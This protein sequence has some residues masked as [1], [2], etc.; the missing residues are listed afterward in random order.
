M[1]IK[2]IEEKFGVKVIVKKTRCCFCIEPEKIEEVARFFIF[3]GARLAAITGIDGSREV[4]LL[5][6]FTIKNMVISVKT[7]LK[8]PS[9]KIKSITS[10]IHNASWHEREIHDLFNVN[11]LN[12]PDLKPLIIFEE[13]KTSS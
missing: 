3:S 6:H 7:K 5:Y 2:K 13:E 9:Q 8:K 1:E 4:E 10:I 12:H 11:F